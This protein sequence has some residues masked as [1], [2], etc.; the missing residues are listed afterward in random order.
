MKYCFDCFL[1][2]FDAWKPYPNPPLSF[3]RG[4]VVFSFEDDANSKSFWF[5]TSEPLTIL[6]A[7]SVMQ[8]MLLQQHPISSSSLLGK[9]ASF[10]FPKSSSASIIIVQRIRKF[11]VA[12]QQVQRGAVF[13]IGNFSFYRN[14]M[15][16]NNFWEWQQ[17]KLTVLQ[18]MWISWY[19]QIT[20]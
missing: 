12:E 9:D 5:A 10:F 16:F 17:M 4:R 8:L 20:E 13:S 18:V 3:S 6:G 15:L 19:S 11:A 2:T 7:F 14:K 1:L